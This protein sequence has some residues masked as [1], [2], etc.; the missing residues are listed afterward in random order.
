[1][2]TRFV[3]YGAFGCLME[4]AFTG[5]WQLRNKNMRLTSTTSI[6]MF[7]IYGM[8]V[9]LEPFF[10]VLAPT[11]FLFRSLVYATCIYVGEFAAG[12][13]LKKARICP[14]DYSHCPV[15]VKGVIR[16]DYLPAWMLAGLIFERVYWGIMSFT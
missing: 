13:L 10:R 5:L 3:I 7:F 9:V 14:W 11:N 16:L 12:M 1:M 15:H 6:W 2:M 8:V 4:V